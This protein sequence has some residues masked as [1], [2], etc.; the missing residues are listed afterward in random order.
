M[1]LWQIYLYGALIAA[2]GT[3]VAADLFSADH[4]SSKHHTGLTLL[5]GMLWPVLLI[6]LLQF[7]CISILGKAMRTR[8]TPRR[9]PRLPAGR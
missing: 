8:S 5:A 2:A 7:G 4:S 3:S 6:G 9:V 1:L